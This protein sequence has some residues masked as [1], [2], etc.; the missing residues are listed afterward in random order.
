MT[1]NI[2]GYGGGVG[3]ISSGPLICTMTTDYPVTSS[4]NFPVIWNNIVSSSPFISYNTSTG[5]FT[6]TY[7]GIFT[8][9]T[10]FSFSN[11]TSVGNVFLVQLLNGVGSGADNLWGTAVANPTNKQIIF[12]KTDEY[13]LAV[14]DTVAFQVSGMSGNTI[15]GIPTATRVHAMLIS[16]GT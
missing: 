2:S 7:S 13:L 11:V 3:A 6:S 9:Q 15:D 4:S 12:W 5:V 1:T 14:G 16:G 8:F 10:F